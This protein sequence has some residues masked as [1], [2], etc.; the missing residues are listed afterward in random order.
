MKKFY[1]YK[2]LLFGLSISLACAGQAVF[3]DSTY[4]KVD[5]SNEVSSDVLQPYEGSDA[6]FGKENDMTTV[7]EKAHS[8]KEKVKKGAHTLAKKTKESAHSVSKG[9]KKAGRATAR[10]AKKTANRVEEGIDA[11]KDAAKNATD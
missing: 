2:S 6:Q 9:V 8:A 1:V 11:A 7:K 10:V 3:A 4:T 5:S